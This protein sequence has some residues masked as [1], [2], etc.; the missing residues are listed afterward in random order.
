[1]HDRVWH[2]L[3]DNVEREV[4]IGQ[5]ADVAADLVT[6]QLVP[7]PDP[8]L[9]RLDRHEAAC[10]HLEVV[11]GRGKVQRGGPAEIAVAAEYQYS[12]CRSNCPRPP[13]GPPPGPALGPDA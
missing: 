4:R 7:D 6:G 11:A 5:I 12:H 3:A 13:S 1:M 9:K 10:A 8:G 2:E